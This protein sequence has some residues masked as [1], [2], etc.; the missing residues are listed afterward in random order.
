LKSSSGWAKTNELVHIKA[1][2]MLC[3]EDHSI[4][5]PVASLPV[6][7]VFCL[8]GQP[9]TAQSDRLEIDK[10]YQQAQTADTE[11][12]YSILAGDNLPYLVNVTQGGLD[13]ILTL[14]DDHGSRT[15][16]NSPISRDD[17]EYIYLEPGSRRLELS[18][19][20]DELTETIANYEIQVV[21]LPDGGKA[22]GWYLMSV[23]SAAYAAG[24]LP[25][26]YAAY[27]S[28]AEKWEALGESRLTAQALYS[29]AMI[30]YWWFGEWNR[31]ISLAQRAS[32]L[33]SAAEQR[34]LAANTQK[35]I[36][37]ALI[38]LANEVTQSSSNYEVSPER[39]KYF[40]QALRLFDDVIV[41]HNELGNGYDVAE[42]LNYIGLTQYYM[43]NFPEARSFYER[44]EASYAELG[45][46]RGQAQVQNNLA[47]L[48]IDDGRYQAAAAALERS[49]A[50][51]RPDRSDQLYADL[52]DNLGNTYRLSGAIDSSLSAFSEALNVHGDIGDRIGEGRSLFG[53]GQTY[54]SIGEL[55]LANGYL[56]RALPIL[57]ETN[58]GRTEHVALR[59]L[60]D[61]AYLDDNY[62]QALLRHSAALERAT[63]AREKVAI[64]G[65]VCRDLIRLRRFDEALETA[66]QMLRAAEETGSQLLITRAKVNYGAS[67]LAQSAVE[68]AQAVLSAALETAESL[69]LSEDRAEILFQLSRAEETMGHLV[70]AANFGEQAIG[71][72]ETL[73][74]QIA[75]P[76][77]R[78]FFMA[79]GR[80]YF[81]EQIAVL[82]E[83][84][85][86]TGKRDY[87]DAGFDVS[88]RSR[89]R[90]MVELLREA[91]VD[92]YRTIDEEISNEQEALLHKMDSLRRRTLTTT[93]SE[94]LRGLQA[95]M[96]SIEHE[97]HLI[98]TDIR[99]RAP[100][101]AGMDGRQALNAS[102]VQAALDEDVVLLQYTVNRA[103]SFVWVITSDSIDVVQLSDQATIEDAALQAFRSMS[104]PGSRSAE[105]EDI[106][107]LSKLVLT[108]IEHLITRRKIL[109]VTEGSLQYVP[110]G[111]LRSSEAGDSEL[112][113]RHDVITVPSITTAIALRRDTSAPKVLA[114]F[115]DP[116]FSLGDPRIA[117]DQPEDHAQISVPEQDSRNDLHRL[118][119]A[120][121]E[122]DSIAGLIP[123]EDRFVATGFDASRE[124][125]LS[126]RLDQYQY[127]HFATHGLID[128]RYPALS[129]LVLSGL[130]PQLHSIDAHLRLNDIYRLKL[131]A[132]LVVLS[133][134]DTALGRAVRG[135]GL[136]GLTQGFLYVGAQGLIVSLW[137]V[138]DRV[139][140]DLMS[141]FY[142]GIFKHG[143]SPPESLRRAQMAISAQGRW[144][145]PYYWGAFIYVGDWR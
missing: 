141:E 63:T 40:D 79:K 115:A 97:L 91:S 14:I 75:D 111:L 100:A 25:K 96:T 102:Q 144:R 139:T 68:E 38:E 140:A 83:L 55:E 109:V 4:V 5:G 9:A 32:S 7:L 77:L 82:M 51:I 50:I 71:Q 78:A 19:T 119:F 17:D 2:E 118:P 128:T 125:V 105:R 21:P 117:G 44:A 121:D 74:D 43:G 36:G 129:S 3:A 94:A 45:E 64:N 107:R 136:I 112:L 142:T 47:V 106:E 116:I 98:D 123:P 65:A 110:F 41:T 99:R 56:Q 145:P 130:D 69:A 126:A 59:Y 62:E 10:T 12:T 58:D 31:S 60:G 135:E 88:E 53:L 95:D 113:T 108:P 84:Y 54:F 73:R 131:D 23:A 93:S 35:L 52:L 6:A 122:A 81:D 49:L 101:I 46:I 57:R 124:A 76:E 80:D 27:L 42:V 34:S 37:L 48:D 30:D 104:S 67:L 1:T 70:Q 138:P 33:Y 28:A 103:G 39:Q 127:I 134:C 13:L 15:K 66:E 90:M 92:L 18:V 20:S 8:A 72:F 11:R 120:G 143:W 85:Q 24:E 86:R 133:A 61:I 29:A 16:Y 22:E 89:A 114:M 132:T 26:S 87:V 137:Q